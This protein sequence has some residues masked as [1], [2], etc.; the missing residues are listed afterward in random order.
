MQWGF[1]TFQDYFEVLLVPIVLGVSACFFPRLWQNRQKKLEIKVEL[2]AEMSE[3]V[4]SIIA[5]TDVIYKKTAEIGTTQSNLKEL[6]NELEKIEKDWKVGCCVIGSKIH[7][8]YPKLKNK[9]LITQYR[10]TPHVFEDLQQMKGISQKVIESLDKEIYD[11]KINS[12]YEEA[13]NMNE[14]VQLLN[15]N[16][17]DLDKRNEDCI[18]NNS[19]MALND[20]WSYLCDKMEKYQNKILQFVDEEDKKKPDTKNLSR[21]RS[22]ILHGKYLLI[23]EV[24]DRNITGINFMDLSWFKIKKDKQEFE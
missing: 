23:Q 7:A 22:S 10:I 5:K 1:E 14:F 6:K 21:T 18:V 9:N 4:M 15:D 12:K 16:L 19:K 24:L 13:R 17:K 11:K 8:Y 3:S 20:M 2:V